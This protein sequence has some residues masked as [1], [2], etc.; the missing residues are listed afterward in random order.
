MGQTHG[1]EA[2]TDGWV[3]FDFKHDPGLARDINGFWYNQWGATIPLLVMHRQLCVKFRHFPG[4]TGSNSEVG[5]QTMK[6]FYEKMGMTFY[7][8]IRG[9]VYR[10]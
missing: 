7:K 9:V 10:S 2:V 6:L 8:V 5:D 3:A 4:H 1:I